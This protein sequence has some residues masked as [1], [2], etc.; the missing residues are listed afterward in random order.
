M[1]VPLD[2]S[3]VNERKGARFWK[4]RTIFF[5]MFGS[6]DRIIKPTFECRING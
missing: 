5:E 2:S 4:A 1:Q 6:H 3:T